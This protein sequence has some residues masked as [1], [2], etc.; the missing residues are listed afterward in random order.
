M[1]DDG[2]Q[3]K[4]KHFQIV[5]FRMTMFALGMDMK[6]IFQTNEI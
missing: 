3:E 4:S 6:E 5:I 1:Y 2:E